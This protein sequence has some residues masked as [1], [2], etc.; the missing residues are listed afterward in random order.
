MTTDRPVIR[1]II[2]KAVCGKG[3]YKYQRSIDLDMPA[4][5]TMIQVLGNYVSN[6]VLDTASVVDNPLQGKTVKVKGHYDVHVWYAFNQDTKAAKTTVTFTEYIPILTYEGESIS[7]Q[8][9]FARITQKPRCYK[10]Y[11]KNAGDKSIIRVEIELGL[12]AEIV[13]LVKLKVGITPS[14]SSLVKP[15]KGQELLPPTK[16]TTIELDNSSSNLILDLKCDEDLQEEDDD[17]YC[18]SQNE[19]DL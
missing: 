14:V 6:A 2:T 7:H 12:A 17:C 10:A 18:L 4:G 15:I 8:Q 5:N 13:G 16:K 3:N 1:E 9:A 19:Y 11:V